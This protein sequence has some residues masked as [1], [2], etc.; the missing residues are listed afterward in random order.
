M[1]FQST[2]PIAF[3]LALTDWDLEPV[4]GRLGV[5]GL[6]G[7]VI[8]YWA[9]RLRAKFELLPIVALVGAL[10]RLHRLRLGQLSSARAAS[11]SSSCVFGETFGKTLATLPSASITKVERCTP[12][13]FFPYM[14]FST[15]V[16]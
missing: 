14:L 16:P 6:A 13:Y 7:G 4:R 5:L 10:R 9:L 12:Q 15:Q 2:I 3:G 8:A 1:V 11:T